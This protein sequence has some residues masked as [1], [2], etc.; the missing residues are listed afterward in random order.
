MQE[1]G[2][3]KIIRQVRVF[4]AKK[5]HNC[6]HISPSHIKR[7]RRS[8]HQNQQVSKKN[9]PNHKGKQ[10]QSN[11]K[12]RKKWKL[13]RK[14]FCKVQKYASKIGQ[15]FFFLRVLRRICLNTQQSLFK[16][17]SVDFRLT[18]S[19]LLGSNKKKPYKRK[20]R[21]CQKQITLFSFS[22]K[23]ERKSFFLFCPRSQ[24]RIR[25]EFSFVFWRK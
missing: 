24:G 18:F 15:D 20:V 9:K 2:E 14:Q 10:T 7:R 17:H 1:K 3:G 23:Y 4:W 21:K 11:S 19:Y 16:I 5:L 8:W 12:E 13:R 25:K 6:Q 22:P